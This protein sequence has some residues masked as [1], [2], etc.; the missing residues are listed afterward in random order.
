MHWYWSTICALSVPS[1]NCGNIDFLPH[2]VCSWVSVEGMQL[3]SHCYF[4]GWG[5]YSSTV[6]K[7]LFRS[8]HFVSCRLAVRP[9]AVRVHIFYCWS[10]W[11]SSRS[12]CMP[13]IFISSTIWI[14]FVKIFAILH[15]LN[16]RCFPITH[17]SVISSNIEE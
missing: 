4:S 13:H 6:N 14:L 1:R 12:E 3:V 16:L 2:L 7:I 9:A 8:K 5:H 15:D 11:L 10:V 17:A